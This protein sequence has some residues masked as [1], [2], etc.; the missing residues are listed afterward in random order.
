MLWRNVGTRRFLSFVV[1]VGVQLLQL[2]RTSLIARHGRLGQLLG[3]GQRLAHFAHVENGGSCRWRRQCRVTSGRTHDPD[4]WIKQELN[5]PAKSI[6]EKHTPKKGTGGNVGIQNQKVSGP[7]KD[8]NTRQEQTGG[9]WSRAQRVNRSNGTTLVGM[10][11]HKKVCRR[12]KNTSQRASERERENQPALCSCKGTTVK[13]YRRSSVLF[14]GS[15]YPTIATTP[16]SLHHSNAIQDHLL[17]LFLSLLVLYFYNSA[18][19]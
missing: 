13:S 18:A 9:G 12:A 17:S 19:G 15:G 2:M 3:K 5:F 7:E 11:T 1:I 4:E 16:R 6:E 14:M 10:M 8:G